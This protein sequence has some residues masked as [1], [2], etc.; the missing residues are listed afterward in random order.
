MKADITSLQLSLSSYQTGSDHIVHTYL[1][2][3][4][5]AAEFENFYINDYSPMILSEA[6]HAKANRVVFE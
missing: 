1:T 4:T 6:L 2:S 5:N 3:G